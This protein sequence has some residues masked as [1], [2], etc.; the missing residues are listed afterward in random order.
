MNPLERP[1]CELCAAERPGDAGPIA[2][3]VDEIAVDYQRLLNLDQ[4]DVV[5]N[6]EDFDC[7]V[8]LMGVPA[9]VGV[10]LRDCLHTFCK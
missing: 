5:P 3:Q 7:P 1:G 4:T 6:A 2:A 9:G 10:T 8:C